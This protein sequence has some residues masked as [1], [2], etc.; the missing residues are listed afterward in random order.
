MLSIFR[1]QVRTILPFGKQL[2]WKR[3]PRNAGLTTR[4][5]GVS[6]KPAEEQHE[7]QAVDLNFCGRSDCRAGVYRAMRDRGWR[8]PVDVRLQG[9][10]AHPPREPDDVSRSSRDLA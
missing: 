8:S 9:A 4:T 3:T 5:S 10:G 6:L 7:L 1:M 2:R